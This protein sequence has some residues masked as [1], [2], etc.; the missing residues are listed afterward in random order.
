M[1]LNNN[2]FEGPIPSEWC[3]SEWW[4]FDVADNKG[5]HTWQALPG[6][7]APLAVDPAS[8]F[9]IVMDAAKLYCIVDLVQAYV[10]RF[11]G[12]LKIGL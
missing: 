11:L 1:Y 8:D 7:P 6:D 2:S 4:M 9:S 12:A 5:A 3:D 10:M